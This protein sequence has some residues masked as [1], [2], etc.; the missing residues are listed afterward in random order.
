MGWD[1]PQGADRLRLDS[2]TGLRF[3]AA[4]VVFGVHLV[5]VFYFRSPFA[6]MTRAF[7][8][9]PTGVSFFFVLS[10]FVL[11]WSHRPSDRP[12]SFLRRRLARIGPLHLV[13]WGIA[14]CVLVAFSARPSTLDALGSLVLLSPW[15]PSSSAHLTMNIPSWSL[16]CEL[17]FYA[18][19]PLL[20]LGLAGASRRARW[21]I[22]V[23]ALSLVVSLALLCAPAAQ[24][25]GKEWLVYY[26]P[27]TRL[28]EFVIGIVLALETQADRVPRLPLLPVAGLAAGAYAAAGWSPSSLRLVAV[29]LVP[30]AA[31]VVA[32]AQSDARRRWSLLRSPALVRLGE[33][34]F[35][36]YLVHWP[37]LMLA[38]HLVR[39]TLSDATSV[40]VGLGCLATSVAAAGALHVLVER[41]LELRLRTARPRRTLPPVVATEVAGS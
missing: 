31:L 18:L 5:G 39:G 15:A 1:D 21:L 34:S 24:G 27:P 12:R 37:V 30:Y 2:L 14:G 13:T 11:T 3:V 20:L 19:F 22:V 26:F 38:G 17:F 32:A 23:A 4:F 16:G 7:V 10:G 33:W 29:T 8:Q 6:V 40:V 41:P 35:A 36:F 25:S 28:L 9:G